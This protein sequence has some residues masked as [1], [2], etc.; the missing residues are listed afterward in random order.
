MIIAF[1]EKSYGV[2]LIIVIDKIYK[3]FFAKSMDHYLMTYIETG[4]NK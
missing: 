1:K 3:Y 2:F 4:H